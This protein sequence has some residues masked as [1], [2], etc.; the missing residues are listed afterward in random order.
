MILDA[1]EC[2]LSFEVRAVPPLCT[3]VR[4]EQPSREVFL[5]PQ[6]RISW[7]A[8]IHLKS[9]RRAGLELRQRLENADLRGSKLLHDLELRQHLENTDLRGSKLLHDLLENTTQLTI[10]NYGKS[11][12]IFSHNQS[13]EFHFKLIG[14]SSLSFASPDFLYVCLLLQSF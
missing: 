14:P 9:W 5:E 12:I 4:C 10:V 8:P 1:I 11:E 13:G 3:T 7:R 6:C 2:M